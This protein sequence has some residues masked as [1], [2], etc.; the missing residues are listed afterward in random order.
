VDNN[1]SNSVEEEVLL[2]GISLV[3]QGKD[4][5]EEEIRVAD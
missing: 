5:L 3:Y 4:S 2:L 1:L